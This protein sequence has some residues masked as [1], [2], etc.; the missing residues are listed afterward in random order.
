MVA[1]IAAH[2][3]LDYRVKPDNDETKAG[4]DCQGWR[5]CRLPLLRILRPRHT[6]A[7]EGGSADNAGSDYLPCPPWQYCLEQKSAC[8]PWQ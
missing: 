4:H 8:H 6:T 5:E 2:V 7:R 1:A 3:S